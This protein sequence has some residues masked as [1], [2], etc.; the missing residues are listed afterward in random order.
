MLFI[1]APMA[2]EAAG[3]Q[4]ALR[5]L[6]DARAG[7]RVTGIGRERIAA[8]VAQAAAEGA[9]AILAAGFCGALDPAL[10]A[11]DLHIAGEFHANGHSGGYGRVPGDAVPANAIPA[12]ALL[13][14]RLR[15]AAPDAAAGPSVTVAGI[16]QP[17]AKATLW[18]T[19]AGRTVNMEDYW[20][21]Q[22]A[23]GAGLPFAS[24]RAV[25]DTAGQSLPDCLT[26][27]GITGG[28]GTL[29]LALGVAGHPGRA[30]A[31][32]RLARQSRQAQQRLTRCVMAAL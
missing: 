4:R 16:A 20:A 23:A 19:G 5:R 30:P 6:P 18:Q 26:A 8:G 1:L 14:A 27:D 17:D 3:I 9:T 2:V 13:T 25:L 21:A 15:A 31:L 11:G 32:A 7:V 29:R 22:A 10:R 24:V 28:A 12:D